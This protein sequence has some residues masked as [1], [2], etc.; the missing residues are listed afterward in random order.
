MGRH[1]NDRKCFCPQDGKEGQRD[2]QDPK[3]TNHIKAPRGLRDAVGRVIDLPWEL[4]AD[5]E[6]MLPT[7]V[8]DMMDKTGLAGKPVL[9]VGL[10]LGIVYLTTKYAGI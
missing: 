9:V 2:L 8:E 10:V 5:L 3:Q 1:K 7:G 6:E 4:E